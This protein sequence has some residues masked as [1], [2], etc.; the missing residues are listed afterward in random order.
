[1]LSASTGCGASVTE[2]YF[3]LIRNL[4]KRLGGTKKKTKKTGQKPRF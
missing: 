1:V 3:Y 4:K 2:Q